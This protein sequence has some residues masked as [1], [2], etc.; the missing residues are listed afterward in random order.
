VNL[1]IGQSNLSGLKNRREKRLKGITAEF[2]LSLEGDS[3][4]FSEAGKVKA[5]G[6]LGG[7]RDPLGARG[8]ILC[9]GSELSP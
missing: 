3:G 1:K 5:L 9:F 7:G 8:R 4:L 2:T 6:A